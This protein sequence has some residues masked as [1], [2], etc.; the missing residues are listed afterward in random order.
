MMQPYDR[1]AGRGL[2]RPFLLFV[3][4]PPPWPPPE[5]E[6]AKM[7]LTLSAAEALVTKLRAEQDAAMQDAG[8]GSFRVTLATPGISH[9][10]F[11]DLAILQAAG[12]AAER[13]RA[14]RN[15]EAIRLHPGVFRQ[16][17]SRRAEHCPGCGRCRRGRE[18]GAVPEDLVR[19]G[20][21]SSRFGQVS[22]Q[23]AI[24]LLR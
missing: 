15:L 17:P 20:P 2:A 22:A 9:M 24:R 23:A 13:D 14:V 7:G 5:A 16:E 4:P 21:R 19:L 8:R 11:S 1:A 18:G 10:S 12:D 3:R 6:L